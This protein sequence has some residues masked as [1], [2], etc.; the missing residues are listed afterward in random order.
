M[1]GSGIAT[2]INNL[3]NT[4]NHKDTQLELH[5]LVKELI[6]GLFENKKNLFTHQYNVPIYSISEQFYY[7]KIIG[8]DDILHVPHYNA[9]ILYP[10][11]LIVTVHDIFS[12]L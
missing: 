10:G 4:F 8:K 9:P 2:Y 6:G 12:R 5:Y 7:K 3:I 11:K 1:E